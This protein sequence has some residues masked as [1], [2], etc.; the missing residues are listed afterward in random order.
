LWVGKVLNESNIRLYEDSRYRD[1]PTFPLM[2]NDIITSHLF[3]DPV[4]RYN[5]QR[6]YEVHKQNEASHGIE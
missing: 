1:Y 4:G 3:G 5:P 6:M 2:G